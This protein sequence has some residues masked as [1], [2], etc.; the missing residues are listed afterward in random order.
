MSSLILWEAFKT[1]KRLIISQGKH[2][3]QA[4]GRDLSAFQ[5]TMALSRGQHGQQIQQMYKMSNLTSLW[6]YCVYA[7]IKW[8][9]KMA[10]QPLESEGYFFSSSDDYEYQT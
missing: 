1:F 3:L 7:L 8:N 6:C 2:T 10:Y 5:Q 9:V 4:H